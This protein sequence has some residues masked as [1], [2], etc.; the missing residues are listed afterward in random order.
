MSRTRIEEL[1]VGRTGLSSCINRLTA[2]A[3][4]TKAWK[5]CRIINALEDLL[6]KLRG[7]SPTEC[8]GTQELQHR[9][10][11]TLPYQSDFCIDSVQDLEQLPEAQRSQD[12]ERGQESGD[13]NFS[14][15]PSIVL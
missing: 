9:T 6:R 13:G 10:I 7:G 3:V 5:A 12:S 4:A 8:L 14:V 1:L 15:Y 11:S 2:R